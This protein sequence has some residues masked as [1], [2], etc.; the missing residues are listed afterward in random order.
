VSPDPRQ[1]RPALFLPYSQKI[2]LN[3]PLIRYFY[4]LSPPFPLMVILFHA[5]QLCHNPRRTILCL[6]TQFPY[7]N[8]HCTVLT[9][10]VW[11][12]PRLGARPPSSCCPIGQEWRFAPSALPQPQAHLHLPHDSLHPPQQPLHSPDGEPLLSPV[13]TPMATDGD[14]RPT[15]S[16]QPTH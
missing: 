5:L 16:P 2:V 8:N 10:Q 6:W 7:L 15:A 1:A 12:G 14:L 4:H 11:P 13:T 3:L 9:P